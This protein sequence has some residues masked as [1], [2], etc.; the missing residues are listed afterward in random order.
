MKSLSD[1]VDN[2]HKNESTGLTKDQIATASKAVFD[3][4]SSTLKSG[5]D[6]RIN[7]FGGFSVKQREARTGRNPATGESIQIAASKDVKF[8]VAKTVKDSL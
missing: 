1:I 7:N 6:V 5:E 4:I 8:K 3:Q 2:I